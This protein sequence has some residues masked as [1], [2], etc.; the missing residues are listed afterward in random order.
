MT[1]GLIA[2]ALALVAFLYACV[3]HAGATGYIAVLALAGLPAEQIKP[4]ALLL[5]TLVAGVGCWN[6]LGAGYLPWRRHWP[7]AWIRRA[8][9]AVL[10]LASLKLLA[11]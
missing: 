10:L 5:N 11:A 1:T 7:V 9:A 3:G 4:L 2:A 6:F 8:L